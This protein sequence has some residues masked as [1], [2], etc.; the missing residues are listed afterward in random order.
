MSDRRSNSVKKTHEEWCSEMN[1]LR[2]DFKMPRNF[3][4]FPDP[5]AKERRW[6]VYATAVLPDWLILYCTNTGAQ[7]VI[8]DPAPDEWV[9]SFG[10]EIYPKRWL[11]NARVTLMKEGVATNL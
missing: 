8:K 4:A 6:V 9:W 5:L 7:G 1:R 2:F 3:G 10:C 11:D